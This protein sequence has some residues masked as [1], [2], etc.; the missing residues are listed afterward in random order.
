MIIVKLDMTAPGS[1]IAL[2]TGNHGFPDSPQALIGKHSPTRW[3]A[4]DSY[5]DKDRDGK[6]VRP[7]F[8]ATDASAVKATKRWMR[9]L[10]I[11]PDAD[12]VRIDQEREY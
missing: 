5:G 6:A 10:G 2:I 9:S 4:E 3:Y 8:Y 12:D 7:D 11:D 1:G